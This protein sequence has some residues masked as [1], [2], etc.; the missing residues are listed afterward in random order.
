[1]QKLKRFLKYFRNFYLVVGGAALVWMLFFD[2]FNLIDRIKTDVRINTLE[3]DL[4]F[5]RS[6][7][8]RLEEMRVVLKNDPDELERY[9]RERYRMRRK[10][11]DVF[12]I[13]S[14]KQ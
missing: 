14:D 12:I 3:E 8:E 7:K 6:E 10:N 2:R 9:A 4:S 13:V 1:M 5:Y 11:E